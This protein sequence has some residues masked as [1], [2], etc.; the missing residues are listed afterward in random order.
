M[1]DTGRTVSDAASS[2]RSRWRALCAA[3]LL[4]WGIWG[5]VSKL[6][7]DA[8]GALEG[9]LLFTLGMVPVAVLIAANAARRDLVASTRGVWFGVLNGLLTGLGTLCFFAA[10][11]GASASLVSPIVATYPL[12]T[13][14]LAVLLLR[15]KISAMQAVGA[16]CAV[17]GLELLS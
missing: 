5:L 3:C 1:P 4:L 6:L 11:S 12:V 16:V 17:A 7:A 8:V 10:L 13:V 15:E 14:A 2:V 9:Q